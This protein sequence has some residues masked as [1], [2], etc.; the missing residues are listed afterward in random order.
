MPVYPGRRK[1][2]QRVTIYARS[3]Q[4]EWIVEGSRADA[5]RFEAQKRVE[6]A[7][8]SVTAGRASPT[9]SSFAEEQYEPHARERLARSTWRLVRVYQVATLV[10]HFGPTK[11]VEL[12]TELVESFKTKRLATGN[13]ASSVNNELRVLRTMLR[14][15]KETLAIPVADV[16]IA[17]LKTARPRVSAWSESEVQRLLASV[18][19]TAPELE[20]LVLFLLN[21]GC[22]KGEAIAAH[23]S[24][25]DFRARMLRIP[26]TAEWS[27]K[28]AEARE[29][30]LASSLLSP[31][32]RA[33]ASR[34]HAEYVFP[35][36]RIEGPYSCFPQ[37]LFKRAVTAA[38]LTGS[39]HKTR[40]TFASMFLAACPDLQLLAAILGHS[41]TRVTELYVHMLPDHLERAR[42]VV[43]ISSPKASPTLAKALARAPGHRR[44]VGKK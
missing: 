34:R 2:T 33:W 36:S 37:E 39:P 31:L 20:L 9:F 26:V 3:K 29:V 4:H 27:P 12:T 13:R 15:A 16:K 44:I 42:G 41:L 25:I 10:E 19:S 17:R 43:D 5:V 8:R 30:P 1:G 11:L 24:W 7:T 35:R 18:R 40:H 28:D 6:L 38:K 21:T 14:W 23:W 22:R 32:R